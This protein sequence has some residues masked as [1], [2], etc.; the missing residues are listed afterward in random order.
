M[1]KGV[2]NEPFGY[3]CLIFSHFYRFLQTGFKNMMTSGNITARVPTPIHIQ[4]LLPQAN[5]F[6]EPK[7]ASVRPFGH[8]PGCS[9]HFCQDT[10]NFGL[11]RDR[12]WMDMT[13]RMRSKIGRIVG[14]GSPRERCRIF[15]DARRPS[16]R[17]ASKTKTT[18]RIK[19]FASVF[20]I[21]F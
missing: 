19:S 17:Q 6:H 2:V 11:R 16:S 15:T 14:K 1:S 8:G 7:A 21:A 4:I 3:P 18:R 5:T 12:M 10:L 13:Y 9:F 20:E